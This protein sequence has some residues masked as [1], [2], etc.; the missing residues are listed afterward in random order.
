M[1]LD[2]LLQL[3]IYLA[4]TSPGLFFLVLLVLLLLNPEKIEKWSALL[5]RTIDRAGA[6]AGFAHKRYVKHDLQGRVND[7]VRRLR[8]KVPDAENPKISIEW[9]GPEMDRKAFFD[10]GNVVVRLRRDD[11]R[12]YNFIHATYLFV[13]ESLLRRAKRYVSPSQRDGVSLY[14]CTKIFEEEKPEALSVFLDEYL[15][16]STIDPKSK[17]SKYLDD[18]ETINRTDYFYPVFL[19]ELYYLGEKVFGRRQTGRIVKEVDDLLERLKRIAMRTIGEDTDL[20]YTGSY[21]SF[22]LVIIGKQH[23]LHDSIQPYIGYVRNALVNK[24]VETI[25][26]IALRKNEDRLLEIYAEF[27]R[28]YR[29][30]HLR[31]STSEVHFGSGQTERVDQTLLVMRRKAVPILQGT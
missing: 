9:I 12:H 8:R 22:G 6:F 4:R 31:R 3:L 10:G 29:K 14:V 21:C 18:F 2:T 5:W 27:N 23:V 17:I 26:L 19:Q 25:Y 24:G 1:D 7:F 20:T 28:G 15:H 13:S 11:P 30:E 16:P